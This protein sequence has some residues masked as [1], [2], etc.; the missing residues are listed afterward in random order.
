MTTTAPIV[1]RPL[2]TIPGD[3][4]VRTPEACELLGVSRYTVDRLRKMGQLP[5]VRVS[6][7]VILYKLSDIEKFLD[8]HFNYCTTNPAPAS[9]VPAA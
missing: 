3:R 5:H 2:L 4:W 9:E 1:R 6:E 7:R 8:A